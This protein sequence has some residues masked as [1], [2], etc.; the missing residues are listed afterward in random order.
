VSRSLWKPFGAAARAATAV[1]A[2]G[3]A[4]TDLG[5]W[6]QELQKPSWQ[7]PDWLFGPAWTLI[8]ALCALSAATAWSATS[9]R[10]ERTRILGLFALNALLNVLWSELF[11]GRHR[12]DWALVEVVPFW[13]SIVLLIVALAPIS[14]RASL[15]LLPYLAW[16]AFAAV[17]N[18]AVVRLNPPPG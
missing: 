13:L 18:L 14:R 16:V 5:P 7:P 8:Y 3:A 15:L 9:D 12:P 17:L 11:F 10:I 2:L 6:Y 4:A 1:A